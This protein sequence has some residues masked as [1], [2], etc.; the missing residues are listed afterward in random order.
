MAREIRT[1]STNKPDPDGRSETHGTV[2]DSLEARSNGIVAC[3]YE[4]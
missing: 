2:K 3:A 1:R 4:V